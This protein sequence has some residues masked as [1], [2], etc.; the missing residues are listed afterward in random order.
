MYAAF[1][2]N[3]DFAT[4]YTQD[5]LHPKDTGLTLMGQVWY[6]RLRPILN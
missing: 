3:K 1:V 2:A 6:E 4:A 5:D